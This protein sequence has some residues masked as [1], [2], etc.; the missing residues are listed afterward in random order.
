MLLSTKE[1][2]KL[3]VLRNH[4]REMITEAKVPAT[5]RKD[6]E[7]MQVAFKHLLWIERVLLEESPDRDKLLDNMAAFEHDLGPLLRVTEDM[8][9]ED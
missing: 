3:R 1:L 4:L 9:K 2:R 5:C 6:V 7:S 8:L